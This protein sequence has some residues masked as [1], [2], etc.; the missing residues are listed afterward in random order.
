MTIRFGVAASAL[1]AAL[2]PV[3]SCNPE[4]FLL[5]V[6]LV[7]GMRESYVESCCI[8]LEREAPPSGALRCPP[9][10]DGG[11]AE[12]AS[13]LCQPATEACM[14][15]LLEGGTLRVVGACTQAG[16]PCS[17]ACEDVLV[18][19]KVPDDA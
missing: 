14:E 3:A 5:D 12:R 4:A 2:L 15:T 13:C 16:G 6:G 10:G 9:S 7:P 19:P 17:D 11:D 18:Y 1:L 8:C